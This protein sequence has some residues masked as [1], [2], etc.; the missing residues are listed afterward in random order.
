[1]HEVKE[2]GD[3]AQGNPNWI[4][5]RKIISHLVFTTHRLKQGKNVITKFNIIFVKVDVLIGHK[6]N[7]GIY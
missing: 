2:R 3:I 4:I 7:F 1:M 6:L 5:S